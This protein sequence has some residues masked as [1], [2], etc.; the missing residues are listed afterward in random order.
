MFQMTRVCTLERIPRDCPWARLED[1]G[2]RD[3]TAKQPS[4]RCP[5]SDAST[6]VHFSSKT[7]VM[8]YRDQLHSSVPPIFNPCWRRETATEPLRA[9]VPHHQ[10]INAWFFDFLMPILRCPHAASVSGIEPR[11]E[12]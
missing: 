11:L 10:S 6:G 3:R 4:L 5:I 9:S 1:R 8:S 7:D 2:S 12:S